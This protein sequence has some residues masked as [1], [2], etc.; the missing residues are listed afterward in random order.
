MKT[1]YFLTLG[2]LFAVIVA[3]AQSFRPF[4]PA[5]KSTEQ[6]NTLMRT[7]NSVTSSTC[8]TNPVTLNGQDSATGTAIANGATH[9]CNSNAFY[10]YPNNG[11]S[12]TNIN[13]PCIETVYSTYYTSQATH[14]S[15]TFYEGGANIGCVGPASPCSFPIGGTIPPIS[16]LQGWDLFLSYLDP[17][18][19]HDFVF[20]RNGTITNNPVT[21]QLVDCWSGTA[22]SPA[23]TY[24]NTNP[25]NTTT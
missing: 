3:N 23:T 6:V 14:G 4:F 11:G 7:G 20:C 22:L 17:S 2:L 16:G 1:R 12:T 8:P 25:P 15:E 9:A 21:V 18:L 24:N 10:V 5:N 13:S 19:Q